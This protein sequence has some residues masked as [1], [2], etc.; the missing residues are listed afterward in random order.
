MSPTTLMECGH[1]AQGTD[2]TGAPVCVI[3][4]GIEAAAVK[5]ANDVP[6]LTGRQ[7]KC[8]Y[9]G[10]L[11]D[12]SLKLPFFEFTGDGSHVALNQCK[13]CKFYEKAHAPDR[14]HNNSLICDHFEPAGAQRL[15]RYYC[16]CRGFE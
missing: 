16:G 11:A 15:D 13:H 12:S 4:F 1:V 3:C 14:R 6:D 8:D 7:A 10:K 5:V 9:C 2:A